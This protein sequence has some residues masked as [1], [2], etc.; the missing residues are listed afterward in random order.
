MKQVVYDIEVF[1]NLFT[2]GFISTSIKEDAI[3]RFQQL[4]IEDG[5]T[6]S[7]FRNSL[8]GRMFILSQFESITDTLIELQQFVDNVTIMFG[9]NNSSYDDVLL[10]Y[11][12]YNI[13]TLIAMER[14]GKRNEAL[15]TIYNASQNIINSDRYVFTEQ[16][17]DYKRYKNKPTSVDLQ[18]LNHLDAEGAFVSLKQCQINLRWHNVKEFQ[19]PDICEEDAYYYY[20]YITKGN[21]YEKVS[22]L[23]YPSEWSKVS[24]KINVF[25]RYIPISYID[26][27]I[28]YNINDIMSTLRLY[29]F[30]KSEIQ[31]RA[32]AT[33]KYN[34]NV[35]T[36]A[37]STAGERLIS[38][39]YLK[40]TGETYR[41][42]KDNIDLEPIVVVSKILDPKIEL[43]HP[44]LKGLLD[45]FRNTIIFPTSPSFNHEIIFGGVKLSLGKGGIHSE[46]R[47]R[48]LT[49]T[50]K[51]VYRDCDVDFASKLC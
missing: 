31:Q 33:V 3:K 30:S 8:N 18:K 28:Y 41:E 16:K 10:F 23:D 51:Y 9:Y 25:D 11:I 35:L 32:K 47:P 38:N 1:P 34:V 21:E 2:V 40:Q 13:D 14:N 39:I 5:D 36:L 27:V 17:R 26:S 20:H 19:L 49:S 46:D 4:D 7:L 6:I 37:S 29:I 45:K 48:I 12:L 15:L 24:R 43:H 42:V 50:D 44:V 22:L